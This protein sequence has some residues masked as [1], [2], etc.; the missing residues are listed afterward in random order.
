MRLTGQ[1]GPSQRI[2][3]TSYLKVKTRART[4]QQQPRRSL[5]WGVVALSLLGAVVY[6]GRDG[7]LTWASTLLEHNGLLTLIGTAIR[8]AQHPPTQAP[9][10]SEQ[11]KRAKNVKRRFAGY[12]AVPGQLNVLSSDE[13][14]SAG[15]DMGG[16]NDAKIEFALPDLVRAQTFGAEDLEPL[17]PSNIKGVV[18]LAHTCKSRPEAWFPRDAAT[19]PACLGMPMEREIVRKMVFRGFVP[20]AVA[21]AA[22]KKSSQ[23]W[24]DGDHKAVL[25]VVAAVYRRL[26][27][28]PSAVP[29]FALGV[30]NGAIFLERLAASSPVSRGFWNIS[31]FAMMNGG[32]WRAVDDKRY[33]P[34]LFLCMARNSDLCLHNNST[35]S[36]LRKRGMVSEQFAFEPRP[37]TPSFFS[38]AGRVLTPTDSERLYRAVDQAQLIWPGSGIFVEDPLFGSYRDTVRAI[39]QRTLPHVVPS[40]DSFR[41]PN[42][43]LAQLL[44]LSWGFRE[45]TDEDTDKMLD[46]FVAKS[47]EGREQST[48]GP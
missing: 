43:P 45:V 16:G 24:S 11:D 8:P 29:L 28:S 32:I 41:F 34:I 15:V 21:P 18:L 14:T 2:L 9:F 36:A 7:L 4:Q 39:V 10:L 44:S 37:L 38:D 25:A 12:E 19:C 46:W 35:M 47:G 33:P 22:L 5:W 20:V 6:V 23:C 27:V 26:Q 17:S 31:A 3:H 13:A 40:Q 42:S 30:A 1:T 48:G